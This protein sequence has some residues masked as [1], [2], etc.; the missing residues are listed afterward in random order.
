METS[1]SIIS[2]VHVGVVSRAIHMTILI[3]GYSGAGN[4]CLPSKHRGFFEL[5]REKELRSFQIWSYKEQSE[6]CDYNPY[7]S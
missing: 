2:F 1:I 6:C 7:L 3:D 5:S 4:E